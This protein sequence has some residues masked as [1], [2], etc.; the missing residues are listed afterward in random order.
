MVQFFIKY[1]IPLQ[2]SS[3]YLLAVA[4]LFLRMEKP[5]FVL[6][7]YLWAEDGMVFAAQA[8]KVGWA[9]LFTP[10]A[11]YL[12][13]FQRIIAFI[14][15]LFDVRLLPAFYILGWLLSWFLM[16]HCLY[17]ATQILKIGYGF[18]LLA[19]AVV[20]F[21]PSNGEIH[22]H[23]VNSQW[24]F[25]VCL[26]LA[27]AVDF[28]VVNA[29]K[30]PRNILL[31]L[32]GLTGPFIAILSP[33]LVARLLLLKDWQENKSSYLTLFTALIVMVL[34]IAFGGRLLGTKRVFD[35]AP[36]IDGF[37][38]LAMPGIHTTYKLLF[39]VALVFL[40]CFFK[41]DNRTDWHRISLLLSCAFLCV[42]A[43]SAIFSAGA[44]S[45]YLSSM[46]P[47][48]GR[49]T[50]VPWSILLFLIIFL[51]SKQRTTLFFVIPLLACLTL[52]G[53]RVF[54]LENID[55]H[56]NSFVNFAH[57]ISEVQ[58]PIN[59][60]FSF[61]MVLPRAWQNA[62][63]KTTPITINREETRFVGLESSDYD[64]FRL[65]NDDPQ[66]FIAQ[67]IDCG[68][69]SANTSDIAVE[70]KMS[71]SIAGPMQLFWSDAAGKDS[72]WRIY[73]EG[74]V[75]AQFAFPYKGGLL[76]LRFHPANAK[77][78]Q[79]WAVWDTTGHARF[80]PDNVKDQQISI[81]WP[82]KIWCLPSN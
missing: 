77:K 73:P 49:Y 57:Y 18:T 44:W 26:C 11:G 27:I 24:T 46:A 52:S 54:H 6:G 51:V 14:A 48:G 40:L 17:R 69:N 12:N 80:G 61:S 66:I 22:F 47:T 16:V 25:A 15:N 50:W 76:N 59:P 28:S 4:A 9:A 23:L 31:G 35:F 55:F 10:H 19:L 79:I 45:S 71:R 65:L 60:R 32:F 33:V 70:I 68:D 58:I 8:Q 78:A 43:T 1:K 36:W 39:G 37:F 42:V 75:N 38:S 20:L 21:Q 82:I 7:K 72:M 5:Y 53:F 3:I 29:N 74:K 63:K 64:Q 41:T 30:I 13:T 34:C 62:A 67:P 2:Y 56:F 81:V